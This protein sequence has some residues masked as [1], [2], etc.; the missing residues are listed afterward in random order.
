MVPGERARPARQRRVGAY[1]IAVVLPL[2]TALALVP[3]RVEHSSLVAIIMVIPV[4]VAATL[5]TLG[6]AVVAAVTAGIAYDVTQTQPYWHLAVNDTDDIATALT[7]VAVALVVG[8][9]CSQ[10]VRARAR[11]DNRNSELRHLVEFTTAVARRNADSD[12]ADDACGHL[13]AIL[14]LRRC[15]WHPGYHGTAGPVL[16]PTGALMGYSSALPPDRAV[17]PHY[18]EIPATVGSTELGRF[19]A[20]PHPESTVSI[21]ERLTAA[22]IVA[23]FAS[24]IDDPT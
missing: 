18:L 16:L 19:I 24:V 3:I 4:V 21:E 22:A 20:T 8:V 10:L 13:A 1:I 9:L 12:L 11:D 6:P 15:T 5:G 2:V 7:L 14:N 17:L 23:L